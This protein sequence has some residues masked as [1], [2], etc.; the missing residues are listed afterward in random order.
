MI[1]VRSHNTDLEILETWPVKDKSKS[2]E[3][4]DEKN[5]RCIEIVLGKDPTITVFRYEH[6]TVL[7]ELKEL[8]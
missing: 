5:K 1:K 3:I 6:G 8:I 2:I 4:Y 7:D